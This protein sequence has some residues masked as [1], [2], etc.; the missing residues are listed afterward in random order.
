M[1]MNPPESSPVFDA[2]HVPPAA[3]EL[4]GVEVLRAVIVDGGLHISLRRAFD[5]PEAW[6]MVIA[7]IARHVAR[8][9]A[10]EG[11]FK[12]TETIERIRS[13]FNAEIDSPTDP[14]TTS[15]VS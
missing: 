15:A 8:I 1:A 6:G 10:T 3:F 14:G 11:K 4:G 5:D 12:E 9:Y 13:L 7:D 2:L